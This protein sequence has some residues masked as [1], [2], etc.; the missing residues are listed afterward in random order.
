ML[1]K[2][3]ISPFKALAGVR[4]ENPE[5]GKYRVMQCPT[6]CLTLECSTRN[7]AGERSVPLVPLG[8]HWDLCLTLEMPAGPQSGL[9]I[10]FTLSWETTLNT[11][12]QYVLKS[13]YY[14]SPT[15]DQDTKW[16]HTQKSSHIKGIPKDHS[17]TLSKYDRWLRGQRNGLYTTKSLSYWEQL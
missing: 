6:C 2:D 12:T 1:E 17:G 3:L 5:L 14:P 8:T 13:I 10:L 4:L 15:E 7:A 11:V 16:K 9:P